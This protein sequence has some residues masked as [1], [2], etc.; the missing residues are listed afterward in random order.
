LKTIVASIF[1]LGLLAATAM[2]AA[3]LTISIGDHHHGHRHCTGWG[4]HHRHHDR[5]CR[6]WGY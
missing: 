2:P 4:W 3:A 5:Y 6:G 1:A